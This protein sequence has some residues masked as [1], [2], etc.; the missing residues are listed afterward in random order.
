M[1]LYKYPDMC[2]VKGDGLYGLVWSMY[3]LGL[4]DWA[5]IMSFEFYAPI[6][7]GVEDE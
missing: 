7:A 5:E 2:E 6:M 4:M 3:K 1:K